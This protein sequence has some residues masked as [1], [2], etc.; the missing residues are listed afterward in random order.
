MAEQSQ[1]NFDRATQTAAHLALVEIALGSVVHAL[2]LP[3][4]GH[5]L[6]LNQGFFLCRALSPT[7]TRL[8]M[9]K[10]SIEISTITSLLKSLS[11]AGNK[12][13]PMLSISMQGFLFSAGIA[14]GGI[15]L[16]GQIVGMLLLSLWAFIQ[17][18]ITLFVIHGLVLATIAEFYWKRM[19]QEIPWLADSL[20]VVLIA[21]IAIKL[22]FA[23]CIP[24][25]ARFA[26]SEKI[27]AFQKSLTQKVGAQMMDPNRKNK[28]VMGGVFHDLT[29][30]LFV[31]SMILLVT[32][33]LLTE[34]DYVRIF[35]MSL[36]PLAIAF[37][38]FYLVR[39]PWFAKTL[40]R[41]ASK[42]QYLNQ[43]LIKTNQ[44]YQSVYSAQKTDVK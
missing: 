1:E 12:I 2:K 3:F 29:R 37:L 31:F 17:P 7:Q 13:G 6:S 23:A 34:S 44:V 10:Q 22:I 18:L 32:F 27:E 24:F 14:F 15:G 20:A 8:Q 35:W 39:A 38:I 16:T 36:R 42:N 41:L 30:P 26:S 28:S 19:G 43:I 9:V 25:V 40:S 21:V 11:P 33:F 5:T 4:A